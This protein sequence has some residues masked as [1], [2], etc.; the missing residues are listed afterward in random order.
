MY[1]LNKAAS[2]WLSLFYC[3]TKKNFPLLMVNFSY[4]VLEQIAPVVVDVLACW[5][6]STASFIFFHKCS[7]E[8]RTGKLD[9][10]SITFLYSHSERLA[11]LSLREW[12]GSHVAFSK[13]STERLVWVTIDANCS[14]YYASISKI[15]TQKHLLIYKD[16]LIDMSFLCI[17]LF[18]RIYWVIKKHSKSPFCELQNKE[19]ACH[20]SVNLNFFLTHMDFVILGKRWSIIFF[21]AVSIHSRCWI[22]LRRW[23]EIKRMTILELTSSI[24]S[25]P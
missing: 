13:G 20:T 16:Y 14:E 6:P 9:R 23:K 25:H 12:L 24:L 4:S 8:F 11:Q 21:F 15:Q 2:K 1:I 7:I 10:T 22:P 5:A 18:P 19:S 3:R 17:L